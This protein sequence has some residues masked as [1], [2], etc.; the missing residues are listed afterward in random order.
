MVTK[1]NPK[2]K[3]PTWVEAFERRYEPPTQAELKRRQRAL[4]HARKLRKSLDIR[5]LTTEQLIRAVRDEA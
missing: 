2:T 4:K 1:P 5:P 3:K